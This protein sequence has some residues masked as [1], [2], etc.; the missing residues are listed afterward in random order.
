MNNPT[1]SI[2]NQN[3]S[4]KPVIR[5]VKFYKK[6]KKF[7]F[8]LIEKRRIFFVLKIINSFLKLCMKKRGEIKSIFNIIKRIIKT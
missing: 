8:L 7:F 6:I 5:K 1:Q 3:N 2:K 4:Y